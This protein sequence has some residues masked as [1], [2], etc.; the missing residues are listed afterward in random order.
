MTLVYALTLR[1][2]SARTAQEVARVLADAK[3]ELK[4]AEL[5][6]FQEAAVM[7]TGSLSAT[8]R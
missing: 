6:A 3:R 2:G 7:R 8:R 5:M 4:G 1:L